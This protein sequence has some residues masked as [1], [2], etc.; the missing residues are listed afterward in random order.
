MPAEEFGR[1]FGGQLL[2]MTGLE[3][4][5][6]RVVSPEC[7]LLTAVATPSSFHVLQPQET[8]SGNRSHVFACS[9]SIV[10]T[11]PRL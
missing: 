1:R 5:D 3:Q 7:L 10:Q 8:Q 6:R 11:T 2:P 4:A 9:N